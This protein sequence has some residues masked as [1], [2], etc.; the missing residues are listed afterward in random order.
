VTLKRTGTNKILASEDL[1]DL[2]KTLVKRLKKSISDIAYKAYKTKQMS[3]DQI[4][5]VRLA[6]FQFFMEPLK[7][8]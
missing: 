5:A 1:P 2:P 6:F 3:E 4:N 7:H 8:L